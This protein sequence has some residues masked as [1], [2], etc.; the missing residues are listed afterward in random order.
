MECLC[1]AAEALEKEVGTGRFEVLFTTDKDFN[2]YSRWL[3]RRWGHVQSIRF[4]GFMN[5]EHLKELYAHT[6]CLVFPSQVETWGLPIS[7]FAVTGRL[8]LL[9]D[10]PYAHE[11]AAGSHHTAFFDPHNPNILKQL[12]KD[13]LEGRVAAFQSISEIPKEPPVVHDWKLLFKHLI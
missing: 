7:E 6:D 10:L 12:M 8:M 3:H 11:T 9:A 2:R 1:E 5:K 13:A 4:C